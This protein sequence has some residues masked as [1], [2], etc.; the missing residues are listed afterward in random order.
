[1]S[2]LIFSAT[3]NYYLWELIAVESE[4]QLFVTCT[5]IL[6]TVQLTSKECHIPQCAVL[7]DKIIL[8]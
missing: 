1:M 5:S 4:C 8:H 7:D 6:M 2:H 3:K